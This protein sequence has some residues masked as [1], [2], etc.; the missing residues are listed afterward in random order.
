MI[1]CREFCATLETFVDGELP[2]ER[3]VDAECHISTCRHCAE[4]VRFER[5]LRSSIKQVVRQEVGSTAELQQRLARVLVA[6]RTRHSL[7]ACTS[8]NVDGSTLAAQRHPD[9]P[10]RRIRRS[11]ELSSRQNFPQS[12]GSMQWRT[13]LP[14]AAVAAGAILYAG[15]QKAPATK[16]SYARTSDVKLSEL[17]SY[18]DLMVS[19]HQAARHQVQPIQFSHEERLEPPFQ[20]PPIQDIRTVE[21]LNSAPPVFRGTSSAYQVRGHRVTF[22]AYEA[23]AAPLR[24]RLEGYSLRGRVVYAGKRQ[25]YSVATVEEGPVGYAM[26]SDFTPQESAEVIA[27]AVES[28]V[29]H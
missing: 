20:L 28:R 25:G 26:A 13:L 21:Y 10:A 23:T 22:F 14:L 7:Q 12:R 9:R 19:R 1:A 5:A 8:L 29:Q 3:A 27:S 15:I 17:D 6:E 18:L 2:V 4:R 11:L 24:A 16:T